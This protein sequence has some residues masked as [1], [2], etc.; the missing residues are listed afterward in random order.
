MIG[1]PVCGK[2]YQNTASLHKHGRDV[3]NVQIVA[4]LAANSYR[5]MLNPLIVFTV[6][7][8]LGYTCMC[9]TLHF[10][11]PLFKGL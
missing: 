8:S 1:C 2:G 11:L 3:Y 4:S 7:L 6:V 9:I 10:D 5:G